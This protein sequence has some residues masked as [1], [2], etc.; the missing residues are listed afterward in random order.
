MPTSARLGDVQPIWKQCFP[1]LLLLFFVTVFYLPSARNDFVYDDHTLIRDQPTPRSLLETLNVFGERHWD[2]LP[3]YR[4][5]SRLTM[6][7]QKYFHGDVP[8]LY[9]V[10]NALLMGVAAGMAYLL[11]R[12]PVWNIP[13]SVAALAAGLFA[14]HP[15]A[16]NTVYPICSGRETSIPAV[17]VIASTYAYLRPGRVWYA[18][19]M[20]LLPLAL[21]S[22]E[23]AIILPALFVLA[24]STRLSEAPARRDV[25]RWVTRYLPVA[26]IM[27]G[28]FLIRWNLFATTGEHKLA[29]LEAPWKPLASFAFAAQTT[30]AP[31]AEL[32]YEP[33]LEVWLSWIRL[34]LATAILV[35]IV[36]QARALW[37]SL[38]A[39]LLFWL[40]WII[41][42]LLPTANILE[43]ETMFAER[44]V[45][46]SLLGTG[47]II[48]MLVSAHWHRLQVR[49]A[50]WLIGTAAT[51]YCGTVSFQ[52]AMY[53]QNDEAFL[54]QWAHTDPQLAQPRI[55]LGEHLLERQEFS[56]ALEQ[57]AAAVQLA[58]DSASVHNMLG[59]V[60]LAV[61]D[62]ETAERH[63]L[64]SVKL[65]PGNADMHHNFG[66]LLAI[67]G[68]FAAASDQFQEAIRLQPT[69]VLAHLNLG[70][71]SVKQKQHAQAAQHFRR[72]IELSP[73]YVEAY[74]GLGDA[75]VAQGQLSQAQDAYVQAL[76]IDPAYT[77]AQERLQ[78]IREELSDGQ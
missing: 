53:F 12:L 50:C 44:Y 75:L 3:Y 55:S 38:R 25:R 35:A 1:P 5:V 68:K 32:R 52:R 47:A 10:F 22:K 8:E 65:D 67:Q 27:V 43:Q 29:V 23:Q 63:S 61:G 6:V 18:V 57:L 70:N 21:L 46:L 58:P 37:S 74:V 7:V 59:E 66:V 11:L 42:S 19:A 45:F 34:P 28:Y 33:R 60:L 72:T 26:C 4:P 31:Y 9:H 15:A 62:V 39:P 78:Q 41:L 56:A 49:K 24:D 14:L 76:E 16:A 48:A 13:T 71:T 73:D 20:L 2:D 17:L 64:M 54:L 51:I 40:G 30:F 77:L 36:F 69:H